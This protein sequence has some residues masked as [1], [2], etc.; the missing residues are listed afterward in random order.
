MGKLCSAE[1][2]QHI[3]LATKVL[4]RLKRDK[5]VLLL[6]GSPDAELQ[7]A[8]DLEPRLHALLNQMP[9]E[10]RDLTQDRTS[11][12]KIVKSLV[13]SSGSMSEVSVHGV[14]KCN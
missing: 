7:T 10:Q 5:D 2:L 11:L 6:G 3:R 4:A 1:E 14:R 9:L 12:A 13:E 8:L